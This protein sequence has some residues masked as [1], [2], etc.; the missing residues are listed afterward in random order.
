MIFTIQHAVLEDH[1]GEYGGVADISS[2]GVVFSLFNSTVTNNNAAQYGGFASVADGASLEIRDSKV[3]NNEAIFGGGLYLTNGFASIY[4]SIFE[5]NSALDSG[6]VVKIY[7]GR[8]SI[9]SSIFRFNSALDSGGVLHCERSSILNVSTSTFIENSATENGGVLY[10]S[11]DTLL[12]SL[13]NTFTKNIAYAFGGLLYSEKSGVFSF[14]STTSTNNTALTGGGSF[15]SRTN[16]NLSVVE[17]MFT[18][19]SAGDISYGGAMHFSNPLEIVMTKNIF[20]D[21]KG[22][23]GAAL[24]IQGT[25]S[26]N[27]LSVITILETRFIRNQFITLM[28]STTRYA[29]CVD[30]TSGNGGAIYFK[31]NLRSKVQIIGSTFQQ[32]SGCNGGAV[33]VTGGNGVEVK[34]S[35]FIENVAT[36]GGGAMFWKVVS[37]STPLIT[38]ESITDL[39]NK[40]KYGSLIATDKSKLTISHDSNLESS[41]HVFQSPV[42]VYVQVSSPSPPFPS[43]P[44]LVTDSSL[45]PCSCSCSLCSRCRIIINK[46]S[47]QI[48]LL[49]L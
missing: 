27:L 15:Y 26:L 14:T 31:E 36:V 29:K 11:D 37:S 33:F 19:D 1:H 34:D 10:A 43:L 9:E 30:G 32:N 2:N 7:S 44:L 28:N 21:C 20:R 35:N 41:G 42:I 47:L 22:G 18:G 38:T 3:T 39:N 13:S 12:V 6:G 23:S 25:N 17:S 40:A 5:N 8:L 4:D 16:F 48:S 49:L 45:P 24:Q 46:L